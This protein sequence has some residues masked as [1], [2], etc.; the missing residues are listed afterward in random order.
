MSSDFTE[1][2]KIKMVDQLKQ[3]S[4][5]D[6]EFFLRSLLESNE[7]NFE[8]CTAMLAENLQ[9]SRSLNLLVQI[10]FEEQLYTYHMRPFDTIL[11]VKDRLRQDTNIVPSEQMLL[12]STTQI[13]PENNTVLSQIA[14]NDILTL[15]LLTPNSTA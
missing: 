4:G 5:C 1:E 12:V 10:H 2:E 3:L 7:F 14:S 13:E 9:A 8:A 11:T 6:D 15:H